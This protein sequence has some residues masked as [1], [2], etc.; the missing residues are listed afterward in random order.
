[1][2]FDA[3]LFDCDGVLV[4][5]EAITLGVLRHMLEERGWVMSF[6][7]CVQEFLGRLVRDNAAKIEQKTGQ[8]VTQEWMNTFLDRR[9]A[10]LRAE[11]C[12]IDGVAPALVKIAAT[13][14]SRM[15][16]ASGADRRKISL[17]L[18]K[19]GLADYF[20]DRI[21]SGYEQPRSKPAPDVYLAA[22][23]HLGVDPVRCAVIEDSAAGIKSGVAAGARVFAF[24]H[25]HSP[26]VQVMGGAA[27]VAAQ[28]LALGA[29]ACFSDMSELPGLVC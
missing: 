20:S 1:M 13:Y 28:A 11:L 10:A 2:R 12:A 9:D 6:E 25:S 8:P 18:E 24:V 4:D 7:Q 3:V 21:F 17:Q 19:V 23:K 14:G 15:A 27:A 5:S 26:A 16:C 22:A 29:H